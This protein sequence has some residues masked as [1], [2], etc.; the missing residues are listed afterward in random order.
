MVWHTYR[1][2]CEWKC[3][4]DHFHRWNSDGCCFTALYFHVQWCNHIT[5]TY[6]IIFKWA[7]EAESAQ[8]LRN[9][10][11]HCNKCYRSI[12]NHNDSVNKHTPLS[13]PPAVYRTTCF[14][15]SRKQFRDFTSKDCTK[16]RVSCK[17]NG[18]VKRTKGFS[19]E[20]E[21]KSGWE[22]KRMSRAREWKQRRGSQ[23]RRR[24]INKASRC[25]G[26]NFVLSWFAGT[27]MRGKARRAC[28]RRERAGQVLIKLELKITE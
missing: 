3:K 22:K 23:R 1:G 17:G 16:Y 13:V 4:L 7:L 15:L 14:L 8:T 28:W 19:R 21:R 9:A 25:R 20:R 18:R 12:R 5:S 2:C 24:E 10:I 26:E 6:D 11:Q 27:T